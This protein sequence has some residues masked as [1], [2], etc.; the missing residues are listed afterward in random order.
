MS[1]QAETDHDGPDSGCDDIRAF[2]ITGPDASAEFLYGTGD[3]RL[4]QAGQAGRRIYVDILEPCTGRTWF[5]A[6]R[7]WA[8]RDGVWHWVLDLSLIADTAGGAQ[9][10]GTQSG[11]F[12][13]VAY[14]EARDP[15]TGR[16]R[17]VQTGGFDLTIAGPEIAAPTGSISEMLARVRQLGRAGPLAAQAKAPGAL[18]PLINGMAGLYHKPTVADGVRLPRAAEPHFPE[19]RFIF[20]G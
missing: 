5:G 16:T 12:E 3:P 20:H 17:T 14:F 8:R 2:A 4:D 19:D 7:S 15:Q 13:L 6:T 10:F 11:V 18:P 9:G 1:I